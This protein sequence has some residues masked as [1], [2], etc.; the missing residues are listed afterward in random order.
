MLAQLKY[1]I[2]RLKNS[3]LD[4]NWFTKKNLFENVLNETHLQE[5]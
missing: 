5:L 4:I 1:Y 3:R 2:E